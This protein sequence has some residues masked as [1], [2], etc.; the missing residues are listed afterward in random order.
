MSVV[1]SEGQRHD[2]RKSFLYKEVNSWNILVDVW[3][4]SVLHRSANIKDNT[5]NSDLLKDK[6]ERY[7]LL[8]YAFA[9][10]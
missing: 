3:L 9:N 10:F 4:L 7:G 5:Y 6:Q 2:G 1:V 8:P